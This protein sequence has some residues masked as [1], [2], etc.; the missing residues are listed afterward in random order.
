LSGWNTFKDLG[1]F[2]NGQVPSWAMQSHVRGRNTIKIVGR[3]GGGGKENANNDDHDDA[4]SDVTA[5]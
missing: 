3:K 2:P 5:L 1:V 4:E